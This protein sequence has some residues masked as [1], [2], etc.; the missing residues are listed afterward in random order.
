MEAWDEI[1]KRFRSFLH[2]IANYKLPPE[3]KG[4][5][6]SSDIVQKTLLKA[7]ECFEQFKGSS[8][9]EFRGWLR[10]TCFNE[11]KVNQRGF[12]DSKKREINREVRQSEESYQETLDRLV[13]SRQSPRSAAIAREDLA[14]VRNAIAELE[15]DHRTVIQLVIYEHLTWDEVG[16]RMNRSADAARKL[17]ERAIRKLQELLTPPNESRP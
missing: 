5:V 17:F 12:N 8:E 16:R 2:W 10:T 1:L 6:D 14:L 9:E 11:I 3:L 4:K 13:D 15:P 7:H